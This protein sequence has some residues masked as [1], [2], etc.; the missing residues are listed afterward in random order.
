M[1]IYLKFSFKLFVIYNYENCRTPKTD[2]KKSNRKRKTKLPAN[3]DLSVPPDPER[4]LSTNHFFLRFR[5]IDTK[6]FSDGYPDTKEQ[7]L[8]K[9]VNVVHAKSSRAVK[10]WPPVPKINS[11]KKVISMF[12][13]T[14]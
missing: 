13:F 14:N 5:I 11:K 3:V 7:R 1:W 8:G 6:R 4:Y 12:C 10:E 2:K 9:D